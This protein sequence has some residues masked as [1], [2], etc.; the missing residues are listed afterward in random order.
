M[1]THR[2]KEKV[3]LDTTIPSA[4]F[5]KREPEKMK[6]ARQLWKILFL[7]YDVYISDVTVV[8]IT[9]TPDIIRRNQII[10]LTK[11]IPVLLTS[12]EVKKIAQ[13]YIT[14]NIIPEKHL[15]D[16]L[17]LAI[18]SLNKIDFFITWNC[19]HIAGAH[20][21]KK[22]RAYN[23]EIGEFCPEIVIPEEMIGEEV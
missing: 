12:E 23:T 3:Y 11:N 16:A 7:R 13:R 17:H 2:K 21:R 9:A 19:T 4:Y 6:I 5:D 15:E 1:K 18:A 8:E 10:R 14:R 20:K 22:I